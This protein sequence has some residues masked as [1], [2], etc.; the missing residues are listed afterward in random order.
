MDDTG[1][2]CLYIH[3]RARPPRILHVYV[4]LYTFYIGSSY[5]SIVFNSRTRSL[6]SPPPLFLVVLCCEQSMR[7]IYSDA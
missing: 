6:R 7:H 4:R 3:P 5:K 2:V 1:Q